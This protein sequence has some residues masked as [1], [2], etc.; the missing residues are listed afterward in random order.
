M[1]EAAAV[2]WTRA[3]YWSLRRELWEH[4]ALYLAPLAV[5]AFAMLIH[6]L[7]TFTTAGVRSASLADPARSR[8]FMM[9]YDAVTGLIVI[10]AL[11]VGVL[12]A[13]GAL[14]G[15]R[16]DRSVLFWKSLP[17]SDT[18]TVLSKAAVPMLVL[19]V[20]IFG[21]AVAATIVMAALQS[22]VWSLQGFDPRTLWGRLDLPF[23]WLSLLYGLPFMVLWYAPIYAWLLLV[24]A[25]APRWPFM[26]AAAPFLAAFI[27]QHT[28]LHHTVG[29]WALERRLGGGVIQPFSAGGEGKVWIE[30]LSDLEPL[31]LYT[32]PGLW[33]G[34]ALAAAFLAA[35]IHMRRTRGPI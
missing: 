16:R 32:L 24:S 26:W 9:H 11:L 33:V 17:V 14:Y 20:V 21:L 31:R 1:A 25:W 30:R 6:L 29:H 4:R 10:S 12:Y 35:A 23:L 27:V 34:V 3:F 22:F 5:A 7:A 28:I 18:T 13:V 19:P 8:G 2:P 15:E